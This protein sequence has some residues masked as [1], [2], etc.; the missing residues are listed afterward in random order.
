M[1]G[2][3]RVAVV[4][5]GIGGLATG[6]ALH[7]R[8]IDVTVHEQATALGEVG[9]GVQVTPNSLRLLDRFGLGDALRQLGVVLD[10]R[11][12]MYYRMDG[13]PIAPVLTT[14]STGRNPIYGMHRAD[15][16]DVLAGAIPAG[17]VRTGHRC[18]GLRQSEDAVEL[19]FGSGAPVTADVVVAADGIHS[20]LQRH[21]VEPALPVNSG[22]VAYRGL[23]PADVVPSW[24]TDRFELWMGAGKHL[25]VFPVRA[26]TLINYVAFVPSGERAEESWSAPGD[27]AV[28]AQAFRGWDPRIQELLAAVRSTFWWGLYDREPLR[29]WT[30]GRVTLLGDAAHPMLPH[31][32]QGANQSIEDAIA[33][34]IVLADATPE[35]APERLREYEALRHPRTSAVQA[36]ARANGL[37]YDSRYEDLSVRDAELDGVRTFRL[38]LY[39]YDVERAALDARSA[40]QTAAD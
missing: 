22:S 19:E 9:A 7:Q 12:S 23:L 14:D 28:L 20:S 18:T 3:L 33:L 5:G 15:L 4:G 37:R 34:S 31:L 25:L 1:G 2:K 16:V 6:L 32:G 21:V 24:P 36:G 29:R 13:T 39:D 35:T 11:H 27:P 38:S 10:P 30:N 40:L 17:V 26:G 8:G